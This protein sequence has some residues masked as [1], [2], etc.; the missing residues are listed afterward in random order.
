MKSKLQEDVWELIARRNYLQDA[1]KFMLHGKVQQAIGEYQKIIKSDPND[2]LI[3]NTIGDLYLR[4]GNSSEANKCFVRVAENYVR[5]N[6]F[7]KAIAVYRKILNTDADNLDI[8]LTVASLCAKQGLNI[9]A[10]NQY[11]TD[12]SDL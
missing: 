4:Q 11:M 10:R 5:N 3:L 7:L 1:E 2:V 12:C 6:F 9:D 8:N